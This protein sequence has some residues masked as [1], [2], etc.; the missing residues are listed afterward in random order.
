MEKLFKN[1]E[2]NLSNDIFNTIWNNAYQYDGFDDQVS[3]ETF[4]QTLR[5]FTH[6]MTD[7]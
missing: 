3:I 7:R 6:S 4:M 5:K 1:V 2:V